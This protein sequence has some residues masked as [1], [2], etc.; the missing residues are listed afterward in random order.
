V[1]GKIQDTFVTSTA[2]P[3]P[4]RS[5]LENRCV[6]MLG[7][8]TWNSYSQLWAKLDEWGMDNIAG[9]CFFDWTAAADDPPAG[10]NLGPDWW[11]AVDPTGFSGMMQAGAAKGY[12]LGAYN[13]YSVMAP[14]SPVYNASQIAR[15]DDG[16]AK[17]TTAGLPLCS[18]TASGIH[19]L[20]EATLLKNNAGAS[21]A[22]LDVQ[23]YATPTRGSD[24][25]HIDQTT[26]S[27]W[28]K[29]LRAACAD[30]RAWMRTMQDTH[31]GPLLGEASITDPGSNYEFLWGGYCDSTNRCLNTGT[32][33]TPTQ[34]EN[35]RR[36]W[37][38]TPTGWPVV[39][40][41]DWRVYA[42][43][44]VNFGNGFPERLFGFTDGPGFLNPNGSVIYPLTEAALDRYRVYELT[45]GKAALSLT[46]GIPNGIG[47]YT[48]HADL[49]KEYHMTNALQSR[50]TQAP[51]TVIGTACRCGSTTA[52]GRGT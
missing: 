39:P 51:P 37:A 31:Q 47:N 40:E 46:N 22:Y 36:G 13:M 2:A 7:G 5:L 30:Q 48:Y 24:G 6:L 26:G 21:L 32:L 42:P 11:P 8:S 4:Y 52:T 25:D 50:Y 12:V 29:T 28:A 27:A 17:T 14:G 10:Q 35:N 43:L 18:T 20:S 34:F 49:I 15:R 44:Q 38:M 23:T 45:F 41:I 9:F 3:S 1:S 33:K 16:T 19:A